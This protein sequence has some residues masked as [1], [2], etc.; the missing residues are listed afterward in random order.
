MRAVIYHG[1]GDVRVESVPDPTIEQPTDAIVRITTCAICGSDL[2]PYHGRTGVGEVFPIGHEFVG[3]VEEVGP[4]VRGVKRGDRVGAPFSVSCGT[5]FYC[6]NRL[7][8][9][10]TTTGRGIFGFGKRRGSFPG[11][12]A[13]YIRVPFAGH[14]LHHV[15]PEV[16]DEQMIFLSDILPAGYFAALNGSIKPGDSVIVFGCG[17]VGLCAVMAAQLF[18]PSQVFAVDRVGY[19]LEMAKRFGAIPVDASKVDPVAFIQEHTS[20][21]GAEVALEAVGHESALTAAIEA[22]RPGG[23]VSAVGVYVEPTFPFPVGPAFSKG[24]TLRIGT[25]PSRNFTPQLM[26]LMASGRLDP[27]P[28]ITHRMPLEQAKHGY[29]I[30]DRKEEDAVK[31]LLVP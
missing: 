10:C 22:V 25:T 11:A 24:L 19:R 13:E 26:A 20:G 12:Q 21:R 5:C 16:S 15:A 31:V 8:A 27:S 6:I 28:M 14:M 17:P 9:Q 1:K 7:P 2:H 23:T 18:G 30:F 4:D 3:V 29:E